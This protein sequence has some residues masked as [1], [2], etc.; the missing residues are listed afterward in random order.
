M[1]A[2]YFD[3]I[4]HI[5]NL[6]DSEY[7]KNLIILRNAIEIACDDYFQSKSAPKIDLFMIAKE[8]SSP[9]GKGSDSE[10]VHLK[11]GDQNVYLVDSAQFGMEPLV[12]KHFEIV[13]CYLPSFRGEDSDDRHLSQFYHCEAEL[14]GDYNYAMDMAE[15]LVKHLLSEIKEVVAQ[16]NLSFDN[17]NID[18]IDNMIT[19]KFPRIKFDEVYKILEEN[20]F[21]NTIENRDYGRV[22][23]GEGELKAVELVAKNESPIWITDYDRDV[24]P[25]YQKPDPNN[26]DKV[27]NADLIL[28]SARGSFGGEVLGLGQR[29][30]SKESLL[31]SMKRQGVNSTDS[32]GWYLQLRQRSDYKITSGFGM[33]VERL[34]AWILGLKSISD[35]AIYP[36]LKNVEVKY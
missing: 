23:T 12:Q 29:Q 21:G 28:P 18:L 16:K 6:I 20:G 5:D 33:G 31:E 1:K 8:V 13:Y 26:L 2:K 32:Y 19:K 10:P 14:R 24:V 11:L 36:V 30:D 25:F 7:Y 3:P 4:R 17:N 9:M 22:I 34:L 15:G 35:A 27:F